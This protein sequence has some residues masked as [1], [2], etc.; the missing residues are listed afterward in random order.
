MLKGGKKMN[1]FAICSIK[2]LIF[3][4]CIY[5][6]VS[7]WISIHVRRII[8]MSYFN[9][10]KYNDQLSAIISEDLYKQLCYRIRTDHHIKYD[11]KINETF[12]RTIPIVFHNFLRANARFTY[13]YEFSGESSTGEKG[14]Y[15]SHNVPVSID[16][17][18][19]NWNWRVVGIHETP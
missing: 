7:V 10:G 19:S 14:Q 11:T 17:Q 18:F 15:G 1:H 6:F 16:L 2:L 3:S 9:L 5:L 13:S 8:D 12:S 4:I